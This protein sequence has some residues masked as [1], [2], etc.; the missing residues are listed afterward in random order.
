MSSLEEIAKKEFLSNSAEIFPIEFENQRYWIK[1]ARQTKA[2]KIQKFF[3]RFFPLELLM[4]SLNKTALQAL[5]YETS[6]LEKFRSLGINTPKVVYKCDDFFVLE[7]CGK[8]VHSLI[9]KNISEEAFYYYVDLML[10]ELTK[11]HKNGFFHGG[12]QTRNF[13]YK[14]KKIYIIDLEESFSNSTDIETLKFRDFLLFILSFVKMKELSFEVD[15]FFI[16]NRY[17]E[18]TKSDD[19]TQKLRNFSKKISFF[20]W[21]SN[22]SFIKKRLGSDVKN[23]FKLFEILNSLEK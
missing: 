1:R 13:T 5:D 9:R 2:N 22:V 19:L 7:D 8:T 14:E 23:F 6:K 4:P 20:I 17:K 18:L 21:L 3:Y 15:Y 16:I 12:A 10:E 11:I